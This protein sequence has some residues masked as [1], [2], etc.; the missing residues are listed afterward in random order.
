MPE[1]IYLSRREGDRRIHI[2]IADNEIADI[3]DDFPEPGSDAF[4]ATKQLYRVLVE[5]QRMFSP[6]PNEPPGGFGPNP[7]YRCFV[8]DHNGCTSGAN[9]CTCSCHKELAA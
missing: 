7:D 8:T 5:A 6:D 3:L 1:R 4:A 2:E 9:G